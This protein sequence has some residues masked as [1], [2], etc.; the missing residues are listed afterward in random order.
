MKTIKVQSNTITGNRF[1][2]SKAGDVF[3]LLLWQLH[4]SPELRNNPPRIR[5]LEDA[6]MGHTQC[7]LLDEWPDAP[8]FWPL[9]S[10]PK[11]PPAKKRSKAPKEGSQ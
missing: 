1:G 2:E 8:E 4:Y 7:E 9:G 6:Q 3:H 5:L 10:E 11:E